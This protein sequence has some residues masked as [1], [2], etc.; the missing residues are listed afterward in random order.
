MR[1]PWQQ[2]ARSADPLLSIDEWVDMISS[3]SYNGVRYSLPGAKQE[4][5]G[6]TYEGL[7]SRAYGSSPIVFACMATRMLLFS[8][9]S[10]KFRQVRSGGPG[11]LF[12]TAALREL[13]EPWEGGTSG[14]L[15]SRMIM[16]ADLAGNA[17]VVRLGGGLRCLRPDWVTMLIGS[18]ND[19]DIGSW[20]P[21][22]EVVGYSY[23]PGGPGS[24]RDAILYDA[25]Q[26]AHFAPYPDPQAQFRGMSWLTPVIREVMADKATTEHKLQF[27]ERG[28]ARNMVVKL[29]TQDLA[30]YKT[31]IENFKREHEGSANKFKTMFLGAGADVE[32]VGVDFKELDFKMVQAAGETRIA[33]A[34]R[35]PPIIVGLSEG[36]AAATYSNYGQARRAFA[37]ETLRPLWRNVCG[38]LARI[39]AVPSEAQ[40]WYDASD[41]AFLQED[42]KDAADV[43]QLKATAAK[44]F[45]DAGYSPE[46]VVAAV[47]SG[48]MTKLVHTGL[49]SVQLQEP[50][51]QTPAVNGRAQ[52]ALAATKE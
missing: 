11:A 24:G 23:K 19:A 38:S 29:D 50:G 9:A 18:P 8:E 2:E 44:T 6:A 12:G 13:E 47:A 52:L 32:V 48:D 51:V 26:V 33:A 16:H 7:A 37:D 21:E 5:I 36:L 39:V 17:F 1:W 27:L 15:L 41:I 42:Q 14:D 3:F 22:A 40:L 20:D 49:V 31:W 35:I 43:M 28:A 45:V 10:F 34:A 25:N 4:E 30:I 46:S